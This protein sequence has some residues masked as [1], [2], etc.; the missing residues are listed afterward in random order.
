MKGKRS[1]IGSKYTVKILAD[2]TEVDIR[3]YDG[4]M[5]CLKKD[6]VKNLIDKL[7]E[8]HKEMVTE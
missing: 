3:I 2:K 6:Q 4:E 8:F 7:T 5:I 1:I